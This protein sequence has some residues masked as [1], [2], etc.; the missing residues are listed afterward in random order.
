[1]VEA[2]LQLLTHAC[3]NNLAAGIGGTVPATKLL[4]TKFAR[5]YDRDMSPEA[6]AAYNLEQVKNKKRAR[7]N[8]IAIAHGV[9]VNT[10]SGR[11]YYDNGVAQKRRRNGT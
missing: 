10:S 11:R 8:N 3:V 7:Q 6:R 5:V 4:T 1:M 2:P 9:F